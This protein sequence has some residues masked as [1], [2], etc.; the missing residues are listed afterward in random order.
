M[1]IGII[2]ASDSELNPFLPHIEGRVI[3]EYAML[4]FHCGKIRDKDVVAV[5]SG[6]CKVNAAIACQLL[7]D[8]LGADIVINSGVA[9]AISDEL[10]IFDTVISDEIAYHDVADDILTEFHPYMPT[11][12]FHS[13]KRLLTLAKQISGTQTKHKIFFG[14]SVSGEAFITDTGRMHIMKKFNPLSV[15]METAGIAHV[16]YVYNV[17]FIAIRT[18]T[19]TPAKKGIDEFEDN[20]DAASEISAEITMSLLDKIN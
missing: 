15:D 9:G 17:P 7:I 8:K 12:Y 3:R 1:R 6:V 11:V 19:D 4:K 16:C 18:I 20:C 2:C 13:D 14:K 10:N 5:F